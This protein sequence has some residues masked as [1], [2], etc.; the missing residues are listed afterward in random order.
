MAP[1]LLAHAMECAFRGPG[2]DR[3]VKI[4]SVSKSFIPAAVKADGGMCEG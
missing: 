3:P 4:K 2:L 1:A